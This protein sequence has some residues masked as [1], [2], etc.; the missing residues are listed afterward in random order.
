[1]ESS[2]DLAAAT[3][4]V[5]MQSMRLLLDTCKDLAVK[6]EMCDAK[7]AEQMLQIENLQIQLQSQQ[8]QIQRQNVQIQLLQNQ[9]QQV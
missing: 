8:D 7:I 5:N 4:V 2:S 1:M 6:M 9:I 3:H